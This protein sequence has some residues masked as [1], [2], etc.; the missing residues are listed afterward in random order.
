MVGL[1]GLEP[2]RI[3]PRVPKTRACYQFRHSP[4][5]FIYLYYSTKNRSVSSLC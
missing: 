1:V 4:I 2:T 5:L 3:S